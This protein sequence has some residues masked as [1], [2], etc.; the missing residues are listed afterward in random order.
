MTTYYD[1]LRDRVL[2]SSASGQAQVEHLIHSERNALWQRI[3]SNPVYD[4]HARMAALAAFD[5]AASHVLSEHGARFARGPG[6]AWSGQAGPN[7]NGLQADP[8]VTPRE[9]APTGTRSIARDVLFLLL[10]AA[11]GFIVAYFAR[12]SVARLLSFATGAPTELGVQGLSPSPKSFKFVKSQ[13]SPLEG[14]IAVEYALGAPSQSY[15]CEVEATY[16]QI[17]QYVRFENDCQTVA[18][19]FR[20]LPELW[21]NFNYLEG[22]MVFSATIKSPAGGNWTGS[23]SV[24]FSIDGT[25]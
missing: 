9:P 5:E 25:T 3:V 11:L 23:A 18:F 2:Q 10:G 17:L 13:P 4:E 8:Q 20:P 15:A 16:Q 21:A 12:D 22:Y 24:Y 1:Y 7:G 19:K 14:E 6:P